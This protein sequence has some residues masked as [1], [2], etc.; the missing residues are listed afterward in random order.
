MCAFYTLGNEMSTMS[1]GDSGVEA[2]RMDSE[3]DFSPSDVVGL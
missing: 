3:R 1:D 2:N